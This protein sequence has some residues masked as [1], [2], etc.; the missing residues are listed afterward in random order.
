MKK[1][2]TIVGV[3]FAVSVIAFGVSVAA[4]GVSLDKDLGISINGTNYLSKGENGMKKGD[5]FNSAFTAAESEAVTELEIG[6]TSA[7]T[8][9]FY[10]DSV[11]EIQVKFETNRPGTVFSAKIDNNRLVVNE[12]SY[13]FFTWFGSWSQNRLEIRLPKEEYEEMA[14]NTTSGVVK[15]DNLIFD[16]FNS[17]ST[18]GTSE[19]NI[20][21][22]SLK[23]FT[24]S[25]KTT[26]TNCT[27]RKSSS[28]N[29]DTTSGTHTISGFSS[30]RF[31]LG[32]TSGKIT[33]NG[34]S[35]EGDIQLTSGK[36][37]A[38][39]SEWND[40]LDVNVTSG[41]CIINL[42]EGS[43]VS[44][45]VEALSGKMT[46]NKSDGTKMTLSKGDS[47]SPSGENC[48]E[49]KADITSGAVKVNVK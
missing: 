23:A 37:E 15:I 40:D 45:R 25:G 20:F 44:A 22:D 49:I 48:H 14:I 11:S 18:S 6:T 46:I 9:I 16:N 24:T 10:D 13:G 32:A 29:F 12:G 42:P 4:T 5:I 47:V 26:I 7:T 19:Y 36:I 38:N 31:H 27:D 21:A 28:L 30:E 8:D 35:G 2:L 33:A 39:Y 43:N 17:T 1:F 3:I 34:L 41:T